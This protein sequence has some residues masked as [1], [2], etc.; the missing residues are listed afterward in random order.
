MASPSDPLPTGSRPATSA[1]SNAVSDRRAGVQAGMRARIAA[2]VTQLTSS[3]NLR[4]DYSS[5]PGDPGLFGPDSV[6][7]KVHADFTSMIVGGHAVPEEDC[8]VM[9]RKDRSEILRA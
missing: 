8:V 5:P 3:Q 7:W 9:L 6:C 2:G 4:I 1:K